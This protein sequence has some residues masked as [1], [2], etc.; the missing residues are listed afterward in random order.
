MQVISEVGSR[1]VCMIFAIGGN[2]FIPVSEGFGG[3]QRRV[4]LLNVDDAIACNQLL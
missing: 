3:V 4:M 2:D 1:M